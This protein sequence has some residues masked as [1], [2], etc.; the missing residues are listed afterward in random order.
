MNAQ[1][2]AEVQVGELRETFL[3]INTRIIDQDIDP[4]PG[5]DRSIYNSLDDNSLRNGPSDSDRF[6]SCSL[7]SL[8]SRFNAF[9]VE[10]INDDLGAT[11]SK[12]H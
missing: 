12:K 6:T 11:A 9:L 5:V 2:A 3:E 1:E 7:D 8:D 10:V 4:A